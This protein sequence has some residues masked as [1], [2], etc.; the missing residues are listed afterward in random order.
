MIVLLLE[1]G[2]DGQDRM[3]SVSYPGDLTGPEKVS[4]TVWLK[5]Y[6]LLCTV[7][8]CI[9]FYQSQR[10]YKSWR[11]FGAALCRPGPEAGDP[12]FYGNGDK[13]WE[14]GWSSLIADHIWLLW[15]PITHPTTPLSTLHSHRHHCQGRQYAAFCMEECINWDRGPR[16][17]NRTEKEVARVWLMIYR[18]CENW[19]NLSLVSHLGGCFL[20]AEKEMIHETV[21][22][23][24]YYQIKYNPRS[25]QRNK[26]SFL[27]LQKHVKFQLKWFLCWWWAPCCH[28]LDR[29]TWLGSSLPVQCR[30]VW[31][32]GN[33]PILQDP[34]LWYWVFSKESCWLQTISSQVS[35]T[36]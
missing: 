32:D 1:K 27:A 17:Q 30:V 16:V 29:T 18:L 26:H 20:L 22:T 6:A 7:S 8:F 2:R 11:L 13:M 34:T 21:L 3:R 4:L 36:F 31:P 19:T 9:D 12:S 25:Q 15:E 23:A 14:A 28:W 5:K 33:L 10:W 24:C 35:E